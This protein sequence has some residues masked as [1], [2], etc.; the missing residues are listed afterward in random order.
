ME[1]TYISDINKIDAGLSYIGKFSNGSSNAYQVA[2]GENLRVLKVARDNSPQQIMRIKNEKLILELVKDVSGVTH[3][4]RNYDASDLF[5]GAILKEYFEGNTLCD[6][7][8]VGISTEVRGKIKNIVRDL[9]SLGI[10]KL[11]LKKDNIVISPDESDASI[12]DLGFCHKYSK[13]E[14]TSHQFEWRKVKDLCCLENVLN[15]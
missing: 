9:H 2:D 6:A 4:I 15:F 11:D 14:M 10:A 7:K 12:I 5:G 13:D 8:I 1:E 3:G